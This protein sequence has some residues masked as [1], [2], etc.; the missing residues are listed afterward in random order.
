MKWSKD[1]GKALI[2]DKSE[3]VYAEM[4]PEGL[5]KPSFY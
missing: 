3:V 2:S 4:I 1:G 5:D